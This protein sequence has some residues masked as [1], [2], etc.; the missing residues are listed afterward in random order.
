MYDVSTREVPE[1][2]VLT[3]TRRVLTAKAQGAGVSSDQPFFVVFHGHV[4]EESDGPVEVCLPVEGPVEPSGDIAV[5]LEPA[6]RT[7]YTRLSTAHHRSAVPSTSTSSSSAQLISF[8]SCRPV[9]SMGRAALHRR[10]AASFG[11]SAS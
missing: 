6:H 3:L 7:A 1:Q 2:K 4:D 10:Y 9:C 8:R 11:L 5:R